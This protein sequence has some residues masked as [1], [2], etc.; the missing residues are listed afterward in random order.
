VG[1]K[2]RL[3]EALRPRNYGSFRSA[4]FWHTTGKITYSGEIPGVGKIVS[5]EDTEGN[6]VCAMQYEPAA[7]ENIARGVLH[8]PR[9][10]GSCAF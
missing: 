5:F 2:E 4:D 9:R 10:L 6:I 8:G 7:L 1:K 3:H